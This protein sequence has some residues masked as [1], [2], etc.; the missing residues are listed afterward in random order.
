MDELLPLLPS[1]RRVGTGRAVG[2]FVRVTTEIAISVFPTFPEMA[3]S[4]C[5]AFCPARSALI[6]TLES[7]IS[8]MRAA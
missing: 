5:R 2:Q 1:L 3:A 6:S 7:R 8:P 4:I